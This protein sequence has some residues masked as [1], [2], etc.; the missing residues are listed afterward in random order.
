[1]IGKTNGNAAGSPSCEY[2]NIS[3]LT[4]QNSHADLVGVTF[5]V[6]YGSFSGGYV[7]YG[8]DVTISVPS[9]MQYT[10]SFGGIE[11]YKAPSNITYTAIA[12][13]SRNIAAVYQTEIVSVTLSADDGESVA[14]QT[15]T[16]NG[17]THT[18]NGTSITQKVAFGT[19]YEV[20]VNDK[21][22]YTTPAS[23][24][25][26]AAEFSRNL[27]MEYKKMVIGVFVQGVSGTLYAKEEWGNQEEANGIAVL[28]EKCQ[29]VIALDY[30]NLFEWSSAYMTIENIPSS[31]S[32]PDINND[33]DGERYTDAII[34][35]DSQA[36]AA[37]M[38]REFIF[39]NGKIGYL[40]SFAEW[41]VAYDNKENIDSFLQKTHN[42]FAFY[43]F[44]WTSTQA[45]STKAWFSDWNEGNYGY[46]DKISQ[47]CAVRAFCSL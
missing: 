7:W 38:C 13:N 34:E 19:T 46:A 20:Y 14:G 41:Q 29:F 11:G 6:S 43:R 25:Y 10:V 35:Q 32:A 44:H 22:G 42:A 26:T 9:D 5:T 40:G 1:M 16:I 8:Q 45:G 27:V 2:I 17:T 3:L 21:D 39:P 23:Q 24:S 4:N 18:W 33:F 15:V 47:E 12:G 28:T 36:V 31:M 30:I 37:K